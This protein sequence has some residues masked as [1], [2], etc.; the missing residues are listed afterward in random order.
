M[1]RLMVAAAALILAAGL[2]LLARRANDVATLGDNAVIESYT[3][4]ASHGD[5]LLGPYSRFQWHHP[6]PISF[7][8]VAPFYML[9]GALPAGLNAGALAL[10]LAV[11]AIMTSIVVRRAGILPALVLSASTAFYA[12]RVAPVLTSAWNP[13]LVIFATMAL[14][15]VA[16]DTISGSASMLPVVAALA[17]LVGQTHVALLPSTLAVGAAS[18]IGVIASR[19]GKERAASQIS[20]ALLASVAVLLL[21][22]ALPLAEQLTRTPGNISQLWTF[23]VSESHQGQRFASAFSAWSD[24]LV[25]LL[26][27][28][29]V[30]ASG[31]RFR[32]SPI[33]WVEA[34]AVLQMLGLIVT[35]AFAVKARR[36]FVASLATLLLLVSLLTLWS[37]TRIEGAIFDHE[38]FWI[39]GVG[40]LDIALV[41]T[42]VGWLLERRFPA[43]VTSATVVAM[44]CWA[45]FAMC[46]VLGLSN[47]RNEVASSSRP[48]PESEVV[49]TLATELQSYFN[50]EHI[51][52]PLIRIDQDAWPL[53][54]GV[55]T[56]LQKKD[57]PV[58]VEDDWIPM[59]TPAFSATGRET[60]VLAINA[61]PEHVRSLGK[62]GD[63]IVFEHDPLL[64]VHRD[65]AVV[66]R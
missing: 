37:A 32:E 51:I 22:W 29:F 26:R 45:L 55:I 30:V 63:E 58:A 65:A 5:L 48:S 2:V 39:S 17:S 28:D 3:W 23:F 25:G 42:L 66:S 38:V 1:H 46:G 15:V 50:R 24:M 7:F 57:V 4:M 19:W 59:F 43:L 52:R 54:A 36:G 35:I 11:L 16:A 27:P 10:N 13:H 9:S 21:L 14:I 47:L 41:V 33:R 60:V 18:V 61:K 8:W 49:A 64:F 62:P 6:G 53:A 44:L 56:R 40:V 20:R 12:W 34:L 31:I